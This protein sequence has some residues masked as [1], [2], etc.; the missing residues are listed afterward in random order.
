M[1]RSERVVH[2]RSLTRWF[3]DEIAGE[4][5]EGFASQL[6]FH[7][8]TSFSWLF[9]ESIGQFLAFLGIGMVIWSF[10][11]GSVDESYDF[12]AQ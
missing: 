8:S 1:A 9:W 3:D 10:I 7:A 2:R 6:S 12:I 11:N 5:D 4:E